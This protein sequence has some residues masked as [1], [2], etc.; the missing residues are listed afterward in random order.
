MTDQMLEPSPDRPMNDEERDLA[1]QVY[2]AIMAS[3]TQSERS[4]QQADFRLGISDLGFCSEKVR[5][6]VA[7]IPEPPT[8]KLPAFLG[9]A[10]G[11][12]VERACLR[13]WPHA[14]RQGTVQVVIGGDQTEYTLTGHPDLIFPEGKVVD[15]KS[16]EGLLVPQRTGPSQQQQFQRHLYALGAYMANYFEKGLTL[17]EVQ[18]AN[19]WIDRSGRERRVYVHMEPYSPEVVIQAGFW[20][21]DLVYSFLQNEP[22]R[23]EPPREVCAKVCG[24]FQDCRARDTDV[25]GLLTDDAVLAAVDLRLEA[26]ALTREAD[27]MKREAE[28]YLAGVT[29]STGK[30]AIR[31]THVNGGPVSYERKPYD[32]LDIKPLR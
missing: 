20:L 17:E 27:A 15:F 21:D 26:A 23:K 28:S 24:H 6:M 8:D 13:I 12:H 11:D 4:Q 18:V 30:Y 25:Q 1:D 29:G 32:R 19:V 5:R 16:T 10:I 2:E 7:G 9:T 31:W 22:A 14:I 3:A